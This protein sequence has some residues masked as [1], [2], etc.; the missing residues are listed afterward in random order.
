MLVKIILAAALTL[1][2]CTSPGAEDFAP[3]PSRPAEPDRAMPLLRP[4]IPPELDVEQARFLRSRAEEGDPAMQCLYGLALVNGSAGRYDPAEGMEWLRKSA[5]AGDERGGFEYGKK[6][7]SGAHGSPDTAES[8]KWLIPAAEHGNIEAA[9]YAGAAYLSEADVEPNPVEGERWLRRAATSGMAQAQGDL[10]LAYYSGLGGLKQDYGEALRWFTLAA[11]QGNG[12]ACNK[13]GVIH[14]QGLGVQPDPERAI[15]WFSMGANMGDQ[16]AQ[17]NLANSYMNGDWLGRNFIQAARWYE[18]ASLR[19]NTDA[20]YFLGCMY[21]D[22]IG[23]T[24]NA[25]RAREWLT[26]AERGGHKDAV[27]VL[28]KLYTMDDSMPL[29]P[30]DP[31]RVGAGGLLREFA[32]SPLDK[33][34]R[35]RE[36][37]L[38]LDEDVVVSPGDEDGTIYL[39]LPGSPGVIHCEG[40]FGR[41]LESV[42][43]GMVLRGVGAGFT[44]LPGFLRLVDVIIDPQDDNTAA[45]LDATDAAEAR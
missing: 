39:T 1:A 43:P 12:D 25:G 37:I 34:E 41:P 33:I 35:G 11:K 15:L 2:V 14:R 21:A 9:Y 26:M 38:D 42:K 44:G 20:Q 4:Q 28:E 24:R 7:Y 5:E 3:D 19:G 29:S 17:F 27:E 31:A 13:L 40:V 10:G 23:V 45:A 8:L 32:V 22:G 30:A 18:Q 6:L 16:Y 36:V